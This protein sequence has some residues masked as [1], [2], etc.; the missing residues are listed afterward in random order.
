MAMPSLAEMFG[1]LVR[2]DEQQHAAKTVEIFGWVILV[3]GAALLFAPRAVASLLH[4]QP[5]ADQAADYLRIIGL[6][7]SGVGMLYA[8]S[9]RLNA[10]GFVFASLL[11]RPL[12][13]PIMAILWYLGIVPASLALM[14]A[15][16]DFAGFLWTLGA[17]RA[18][19]AN[20]GK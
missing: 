7:A 8:V 10:L 1:R 13:P 19:F 5:L 2:A 9:G 4:I 3:E 18:E 6:L 15:V 17:W 16:Q 11:D 20:R 14:F 12:V